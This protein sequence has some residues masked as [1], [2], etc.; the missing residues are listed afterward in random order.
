MVGLSA[1]G[2]GKVYAQESSLG[3][4]GGACGA[5]GPEAARGNVRL[6]RTLCVRN[7]VVLPLLFRPLPGRKSRGN[8]MSGEKCLE[9]GVLRVFAFAFFF[10]IFHF[11]I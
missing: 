11:L 6:E 2:T 10:A 8:A 1:L 3:P 4:A 5:A 9:H 7:E